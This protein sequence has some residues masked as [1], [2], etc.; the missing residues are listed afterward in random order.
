MKNLICILLMILV[1][2][3]V[4]SDGFME[5]KKEI[6]DI[7]DVTNHDLGKNPFYTSTE[8]GKSAVTE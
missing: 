4:Y 2:L 6:V 3:P 1:C 5:P 7:V 8:A